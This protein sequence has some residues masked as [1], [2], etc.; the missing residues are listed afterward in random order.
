MALSTFGLPPGFRLFAALGQFAFYLA[1]LLDLVIPPRFFLK[2]VTSPIRT[3]V[4]LMTAAFLA[5][6]VFFVSP[7]SLW[8]ETKV[9]HTT[10]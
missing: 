3:F 7:T 2:K 8:K 5:L 6:R 9:R 10:A 1:A 4:V